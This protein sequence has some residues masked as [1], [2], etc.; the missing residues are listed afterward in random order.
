MMPVLHRDFETRSILDLKK[1][2][3]YRYAGEPTTGVWCVTFAVDD[4]PVQ[5]WRPGQPIPEEFRI[6]A[7][8]PD[9]LVAAYNDRFE[10]SIEERLLAPRYS[11]PLVPIER[12][13][14]TMAAALANALPAELGAAAAALDLPIRK[15]ADGRA[16]MLK[17]A[18]PRKPRRGEDPQGGPY[19]DDDP[20][21]LARLC[22]YCVRDVE[23]E[24]ALHHRV[25]PLLESEQALWALDQIINRRG[26]AVDTALAE[27][28]DKIVKARLTAINRAVAALTEGKIER[29]SQL[30]RIEAFLTDHGHTVSGVGKRN[31]AAVLAHHP[32]PEV[33]QLLRLRQEGGK[34]SAAKL[35]SLLAGA[36]NGRLHGT[37]RFHKFA[38]GRWAGTGFQPQNLSRMVPADEEAA[39]AA[40]KSGE[41]D[42][43]AAIGPPI[44][45]VASLSRSLITAA[46]G[47]DLISADYSSIESRLTAWFAGETWK[48]DI[49][50]RFD[51]TG[52]PTIEPYCVT[53]SRI[54]G[55][56][57]TPE[58]EEDRQIGKFCELAFGFGGGI[59]AFKKIAPDSRF[60]DAQIE[61]FKQQWRNAHPATCRFW[62]RLFRMLLR[63]VRTGRAEMLDKGIGAAMRDGNLY[64][65]L[66]SGRE[67]A[68]PQAR[69]RPGRYG[70]E[71]V[72]KDNAKGWQDTSEW[73]GTFVENLVQGTARD[74]L[75]A[76]MHRVESAGYPI[77]LTVHDE[78]VCEIA[79][80]FGDVKEFH[81]LV[82]E[83]P[84]WGAGL[85]FA[86]KV[87]RRKRYAKTKKGAPTM[88]ENH[89]VEPTLAPTVALII[90][91][92]V[93]DA[94]PQPVTAADLDAINAGLQGWGIEPISI[95]TAPEKSNGFAPDTIAAMAFLRTLRR[96]GPW[97]LTA[98]IPDG[99]TTTRTFDASDEEGARRFIETS[100][101]TKNVYFTGNLCGRPSKKPTKADMTGAIF[102]PTDDDPREGETPDAAKARIN[103][104]YDAHDPPPSIVIDSGNGL[105]GLWL[106]DADNMF[107]ELT[108]TEPRPANPK[109]PTP[110]ETA[111]LKAYEQAVEARV[112]DTELRNRALA[113]ALGTTPGTHNVDRL[114]RLPGRINHPNKAKLKKGRVACMA[115]VVRA[116]DA[117][118]ALA[119]FAAAA[120]TADDDGSYSGADET[121]P[122]MLQSLLCIAD[123]GAGGAAGGY[124]TRSHLLF[125]FLTGALRARVARESIAAAC[126]DTAYIGHAIYQHCLENGGRKYLDRQIERAIKAVGAA[127]KSNN[128]AAAVLPPGLTLTLEQWAARDLPVPDHLLGEL[129]S[130]T[131]RMLL[132]ADTGLGKTRFGIA[133]GMRIAAGAEFL[134]WPGCG[135]PRRVLYI[136]GEMS[137]RMLKQCLAEEEAR[138]GCPRP[139]TFF[140]LSC[141]DIPGLQPLNT[142]A[143]QKTIETVIA[144]HCGGAIDLVIFDNIMA[145]IAGN[146]AEEDGWAQTLPWIR[147]LT[148]R[149]I[150]QIWIHHTGH[151]TSRQYGTKTREW[152]M[153]LY[154]QADK[155][156]HDATDICFVLRFPK[157]R[158]RNPGNRHQFSDVQ[159]ALIDDSGCSSGR[160]PSSRSSRHR[161]ARNI[162]TTCVRW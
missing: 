155:I 77:V 24:R 134:H 103:A 50:R 127:P 16:L 92:P 63:V 1:V 59:M 74:L 139:P 109:K 118:Y 160:A 46:P 119:A 158:E 14:C 87:S 125:A 44:E 123:P 69:V 161:N 47:C 31:V 11:W 72:F 33:E 66:P 141:E 126:L 105:Q 41:L 138:L 18:R 122:Q 130:T 4:G 20:D 43:A 35:R 108:L 10:S 120:D 39:I 91:A 54:F 78:L 62:G 129:L 111:K 93:I 152:E 52:D 128:A 112:A 64:M 151:N 38:T 89:D 67:I 85:P 84:A 114:L 96:A 76:A 19:W 101:A 117:R 133:I 2:G 82:I 15:D 13:R 60:S 90:P 115:S 80:D 150:G 71:I 17:M 94:A 30:K 42:R 124:A 162:S 157:A 22:A 140:A 143:G 81:Q 137:N 145:L 149:A 25:P 144:A 37:M 68:Y 136:D 48:L 12:H 8:D 132:A 45:L 23:V 51:D 3:A 70:D 49:F 97:V 40:V 142:E 61:Q 83:L 100:N 153:T 99:A 154:G 86:A 146:H 32:G 75:A 147:D 53:A 73:H 98:I 6:A 9:W 95:N 121:I 21:H 135:K 113:A 79:E 107:P 58:D 27:A 159:I 55:R 106:L 34:A 36:D 104:A 56:P 7:R 156:P 28:G 131:S 88:P 29:I 57:V 5:I 102:L 148:R 110:E 26:F 116:T 65:R